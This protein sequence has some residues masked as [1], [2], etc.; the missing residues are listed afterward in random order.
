MHTLPT[1]PPQ[2]ATPVLLQK[3]ALVVAHPGHELRVYGWMESVRPLVFVLTDGSGS[4]GEAR[5]ESST[6]VL[7]G[8]LA[9]PGSIYGWMSD[10]AIYSAILSHDHAAFQRI[11]DQLAETLAAEEIDCVAGDAVEGYNPSHDV[12]RLVINAAVRMA[13]RARGAPIAAYDFAL[14][15]APDQCAPEL[16]PRAL[17]LELDAQTLARK[18]EAARGYEELA[19]EV[20]HA[21]R[22]FGLAPF[23]TEYLRPVDTDDPYGGWDPAQVPYYESYGE[24]R[25][26]EGVYDQV[27]RF[28]E[29]VQPLADALW[30]HSERQR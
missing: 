1:A 11:A 10:R 4:G 28:R 17:R 6:Q 27:L 8:T 22:Q 19:G 26:A 14:V 3:C 9:R 25:V 18:L 2:T 7:A 21:L 16:R 20:E 30:S 29:H 24:K 5:L 13:G 15:G 23:R 12:C